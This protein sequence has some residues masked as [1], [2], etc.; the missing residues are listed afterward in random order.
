M[1][2][3]GDGLG[4]ATAI[5]ALRIDSDDRLQNTSRCLRYVLSNFGG[6]RVIILEDGAK[7][8]VGEIL[9]ERDV[10]PHKERVSYSFVE[11]HSKIFHRTKRLN[12]CLKK[13]ETPIA[14]IH[15]VDVILPVASM[16]EARRMIAE[17]GYGAVTPFSNPPGCTDVPQKDADALATNSTSHERLV[18][19]CRNHVAGNGFSLFVA[20]KAYADRGGENEDFVSYG[21]EDDARLYS[22]TRLGLKYGR[23]KGRVFHMEHQ[24][25]MNSSP[26]NPMFSHNVRVFQRIEDMDL[27]QLERHFEKR[28]V[29]LD[30]SPLEAGTA[31]G[32]G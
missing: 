14:I 32:S 28:K 9:T 27:P 2:A 22:H 20:T 7:P 11:E 30:R 6:I 1:A 4:D 21:P 15:D 12:Q 29:V 26:S 19:V 25:G 8:R 24:R 10:A 3:M 16:L 31:I 17:D 13:V 23:V 5:L 18:K